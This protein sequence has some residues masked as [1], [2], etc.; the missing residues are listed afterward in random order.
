MHTYCISNFIR[1]GLSCFHHFSPFP[2]YRINEHNNYIHY[3]QNICYIPDIKYIHVCMQMHE[4]N[5]DHTVKDIR[6]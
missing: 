5:Y 2:N 4:P 6:I 1:K 3:I